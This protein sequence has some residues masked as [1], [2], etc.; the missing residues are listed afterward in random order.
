MACVALQGQHPQR[1]QLQGGLPEE[2]AALLLHA[3]V[4]LDGGRGAHA[5]QGW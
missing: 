4:R 3:H 2:A 5:A 1:A